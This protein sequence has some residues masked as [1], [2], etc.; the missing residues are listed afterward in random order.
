MWAYTYYKIVISMTIF[1]LIYLVIKNPGLVDFAWSANYA[2][3]ATNFLIVYW[4]GAYAKP[5]L[6]TVLVYIWF[7]RLGGLIML[8]RIIPGHKDARYENMVDENSNKFLF[9]F[10]QY[11]FQGVLVIICASPLYFCY[12]NN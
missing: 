7:I 1:F 4:T 10:I 6:V 2:I 11:Q 12:Q 8:T 5:I 3:V 9:F